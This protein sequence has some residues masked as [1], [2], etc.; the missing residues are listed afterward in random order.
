MRILRM[1]ATLAA[2][3]LVAGS[4]TTAA[5][6]PSSDD[7]TVTPAVPPVK[8]VG[9]KGS[10]CFWYYG[11]VGNDPLANIAYP[12]AGATYWAAIYRRPHGSKLT[13]KG[14]YPHARYMS[15]ISYDRAGQPV[16]GIG[17]FQIDPDKGSKNPFRPGARRDTRAKDRKFSVAIEHSANFDPAS[18]QPEYTIRD[19]RPDQPVR[20]TLKTVPT[21]SLGQ[22]PLGTEVGSD[23]KTY[24]TESILL[25]VYV[26]DAGKDI[27]GGVRLPEA[28]LTDADGTVLKGQA[29]CDAMDSE[30]KDFGAQ[31]NGATRLPDPSALTLPA[32]VY[33]DLRYPNRIKASRDMLPNTPGVQVQVYP[34]PTAA[35]PKTY[36]APPAGVL[37]QTKRPVLATFP[38]TYDRTVNNRWT[39]RS[40]EWR[41]QYDRR[42]LLQ[43][44]TGDDAVGASLT[45]SRT[46]GGFFP[47]VHNNYVR[48][49]LNRKFGEVAVIR[50][51]MPS[52]P[53]TFRG[54]PVMAKG[55][56]RYTSFCMN[57]ATFT[58]RVMDCAYDED[59]PVDKNGYYTIAVSRS[60][61]RPRNADMRNGI[62]WINWSTRGD[63]YQDPDFGWFQIRN[64]LADVDFHNA[65]Q[66]TAR[67]GDEIK[68][69]RRYL[70]K[71]TYMSTLQF[72]R[73]FND[74]P[75]G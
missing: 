54:N 39:K 75:R 15:L 56:V 3:A 8:L 10:T 13:L 7:P 73:K 61:D 27:R 48:T 45:P 74:K 67:P 5:A 37:F 55:D 32:Q 64:M 50:G 2:A 46:G 42:Y 19:P 63:G 1:S 17:D 14:T 28:T 12:D 26:P 41:A 4:L 57:E 30:S 6:S 65:T 20:N 49:A 53:K 31:H 29:A 69:M 59:V 72:E 71:V 22:V 34:T 11:G 52:S 23:G 43:T 40:T 24:D 35:T 47:N 33:Q 62:T 60:E 44:W 25:R 70:P 18:G 68:K 21:P 36:D 38:A 51:K 9:G 66:D 16:D 58:T